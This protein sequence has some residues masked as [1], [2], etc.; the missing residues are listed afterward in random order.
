M[1]L[2]MKKRPAAYIRMSTQQQENSPE[3]QR[4]QIE[5]YA[6]QKG[7]DIVAWYEDQAMKGWD[8]DR[9]GYQA[10]LR[11][12]RERQFEVIVAD[13][14]SRLTRLATIDYVIHFVGPLSEAG[15]LVDTVSDGVL[16]WDEEN[17]ATVLIHLLKSHKGLAET[18]D[19]ARR[20][21]KGLYTRAR[22][23]KLFVGPSPFGLEYVRDDQGNRIG[24]QP[25]PD[26]E[27]ATVKKMFRWY[28]EG[29]SLADIVAELNRMGLRTRSGR[30]GNRSNVHGI[31]TNP[32]Y[33]GDYVFGRVAR[34]KQYRVSSSAPNGHLRRPK[35]TKK[36][37]HDIQRNPQ[38]DWFV[39]KD[40]HPAIIDRALF[41]NV[42]ELLKVRRKCTSP[43]RT[44]NEHPLSG[45]LF[46]PA[47]GHV[48]YGT[49]R[50]LKERIP[51]YVCGQYVKN[52]GC[53]GCWVREDEALA[54][55]ARAL[56]EKLEDPREVARL[57]DSLRKHQAQAT[58]DGAERVAQ[59]QQQAGRLDGQIADATARLARVPERM[60]DTLLAEIEKMETERA[61]VQTQLAQSNQSPAPA[62]ALDEIIAKVQ[63]LPEAILEADANLINRL[64]RESI[65]R[66]DLTFRVV[67][68]RK[69]KRFIWEEGDISLL[70]SSLLSATGPGPR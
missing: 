26:A 57:K 54:S 50:L 25:G 9:P 12:A 21:T 40:A 61:Q 19:L 45:L 30:E 17:L 39:I 15:V 3:R 13:E 69:N 62:D 66:V 41:E 38:S 51:V 37:Q 52:R 65:E 53:A 1:V 60:F 20:T 43:S 48:M 4:A 36:T 68:L 18:L 24:Y 44:K 27:V 63:R 23:G 14:L 32:V 64:L 55:I 49:T 22:T 42:Q 58:G 29:Y 34:G 33:A 47:C 46:C 56:K 5:A 31:M 11:A 6:A 67:P 10:M 2:A 59:L 28:A 8:I 16:E 35:K 70:K 7:Y